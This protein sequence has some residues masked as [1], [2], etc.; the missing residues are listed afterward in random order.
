M[1]DE[2]IISAEE[3][4]AIRARYQAATP[5]PWSTGGYF[6]PGNNNERQSVYGPQLLREHQSGPCIT[7]RVLTRDAIFIA[8]SRTDIETLDKALT[9]ALAEIER[10]E[11]GGN[12]S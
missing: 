10:L 12:A 9:A 2:V 6:N 11:G 4:T 7:D 5:G 8:A 3:L 1:S